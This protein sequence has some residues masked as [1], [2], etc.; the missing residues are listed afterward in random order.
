MKK[1]IYVVLGTFFMVMGIIG[2]LLPILPTTPFLLLTLYFYTRSSKRFERWFI[3]TKLYQKHLKT[4]VESREMARRD[5][6]MLLIM[7][8]IILITSAIIINRLWVTLLLLFIDGIKYLYFSFYVKTIKKDDIIY[9]ST[10][11]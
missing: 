7:V 4:F 1:F 2:I 3:S 5:K 11:E 9:Q 10:A 8:D 6:W